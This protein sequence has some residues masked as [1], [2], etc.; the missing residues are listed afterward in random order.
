MLIQEG[1]KE[2]VTEKIN[3]EIFYKDVLTLLKILEG[4]GRVDFTLLR[5]KG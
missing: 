4:W 2:V 5:K 3:Y 1:F